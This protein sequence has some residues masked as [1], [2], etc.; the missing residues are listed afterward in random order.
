VSPPQSFLA[1]GGDVYDRESLL[2]VQLN[3][4]AI[5]DV[6]RQLIALYQIGFATRRQLIGVLGAPIG[7]L[8]R[9]PV[10]SQF[11]RPRGSLAAG[12]CTDAS[13]G[14]VGLVKPYDFTV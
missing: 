5:G 12:A 3:C 7:Q 6:W 8:P 10:D 14:P 4:E 2:S 9:G 11:L 13:R 1:S